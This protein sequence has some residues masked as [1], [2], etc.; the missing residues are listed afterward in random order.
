MKRWAW[1]FGAEHGR[2]RVAAAL[3]DDDD[4]LA[5]AVLIASEAAVPAIL[6]Q[7][8]GLHV[9]AEI[10]AIDFRDL[11]FAA[12]HAALHFGGHRFAHLVQQHESGLVGDAQIAAHGERRL[13]FHLVAEDRDGRE[14]GAQRQLVA[15]EQRPGGD[16]EILGKPGIGTGARRSAAALV[17]INAAALRANRLA[18]GVGPADLAE[19]PFRF[20]VRHRKT[21]PARGSWRRGEEEMLGHWRPPSFMKLSL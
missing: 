4:D 15:G 8:G 18:I 11:A 13:A 5:L 20:S 1:R 6:F 17:G 16:A 9:A 10:A 21:P 14:I 3:A 2:E 12:E 19:G 7:I